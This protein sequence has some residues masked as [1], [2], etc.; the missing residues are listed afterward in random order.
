MNLYGELYIQYCAD[1][2]RDFLPE[3]VQKHNSAMKKLSKLFHRLQETPDRTFMLDLLQSTDDQT[4][5]MVAAHCLG[6]N[7]YEDTAKKVLK[8]IARS[9]QNSA[10][11]FNA[12][13]TLEVWKKQGY[14]E[15]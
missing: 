11:A 8:E 10:L 5:L 12:R 14:L 9:N 4:R 7:E 6:L 1:L 13:S 2:S 3:N 15:F